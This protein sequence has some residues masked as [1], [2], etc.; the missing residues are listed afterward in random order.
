[1]A[2][3]PLAGT[4]GLIEPIWIERPHLAAAG[5]IGPAT[6]ATVGVRRAQGLRHSR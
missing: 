1:M 4:R 2:E 5:A 3:P 6:M